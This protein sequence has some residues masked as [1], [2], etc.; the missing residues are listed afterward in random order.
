MPITRSATASSAIDAYTTT[1]PGAST[2]Q[3]RAAREDNPDGAGSDSSGQIQEAPKANAAT[4][5]TATIIKTRMKKGP[6]RY[7]ACFAWR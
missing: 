7:L 4:A 3:Y 2:G 6:L 5:P 1:S